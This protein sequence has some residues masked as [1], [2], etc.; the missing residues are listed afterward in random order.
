MANLL[1]TLESEQILPISLDEAWNYF[2]NPRNLEE[3]TPKDIG[4]KILSCKDDVMREGQMIAYKIKVM[5]AIWV[6]WVTEITYVKE[7]QYFIDDQRHGPYS[8]WH[9]R[10]TFEE[11]E[12]GVL[13][14]D[15]V[16][17]SL[18][19]GIFGSIAH[20]LFV[21]KKLEKIFGYREIML[22]EKFPLKDN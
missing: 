20:S 5:P 6:N 7:K 17:Y 16:H 15:L 12:G 14:K 11:V 13:M 1:H 22:N 21:R 3:L 9:H 4:F 18:P 8:I 19:F 2:S 10:H